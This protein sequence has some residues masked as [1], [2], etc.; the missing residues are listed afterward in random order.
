MQS[1]KQVVKPR[2]YKHP[3]LAGD[4]LS[5]KHNGTRGKQHLHVLLRCT[6]VYS[7]SIQW[8]ELYFL[9]IYDTLNH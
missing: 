2:A 7:L 4:C 9:L 6:E 5:I 3:D 1:L 8:V